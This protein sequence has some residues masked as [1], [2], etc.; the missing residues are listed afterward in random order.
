MA[1]KAK[2]EASLQPCLEGLQ[3]SDTE[4]VA[5]L[6]DEGEA[7]HLFPPRHVQG[8]FWKL[9]PSTMRKQPKEVWVQEVTRQAPGSCLV[10]IMRVFP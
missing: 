4:H 6:H 3:V 7:P 1:P 5:Q 9:Q 8:L 2:A 10:G